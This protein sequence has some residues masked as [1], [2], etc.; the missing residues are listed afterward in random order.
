MTLLCALCVAVPL[1]AASTRV[2]A[3][4]ASTPY[5]LYILIAQLGA[6]PFLVAASDADVI[7]YARAVISTGK[8]P[9]ATHDALRTAARYGDVVDVQHLL[10]A[11]Y[12]DVNHVDNAGWTALIVAAH[13]GHEAVV[14]QLLAVDRIDVNHADNLG[15]T[16]LMG[17]AQQG[18]E[19]VVEQLLAVRGINVNHKEKN[20]YTA[21]MLA[22]RYLRPAEIEA[23]LRGAGAV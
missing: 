11:P 18:H 23:M 8:A 9:T 17:A 1:E 12:L 21:R 4:A 22:I 7:A 3:G 15:Y 6:H 19:A 5:P 20:G 10:T 2:D 13:N 16:A 14:K